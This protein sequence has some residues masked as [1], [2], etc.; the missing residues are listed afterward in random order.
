MNQITISP[1]KIF[2]RKIIFICI[3][4]SATLACNLPFSFTETGDVTPIEDI[5]QEPTPKDSA[6]NQD[7]SSSAAS[8]EPEP[9]E[10]S[11]EDVQ[12]DIQPGAKLAIPDCNIFDIG[13]FNSIVDG[14]F[15]FITQDQL[16]NCHFESNNDFRLLI[17]GGKPISVD[18]MKQLFDASFGTLPDSTWEVKDDHYLG[19]AYSTVS[20]TAQGISS[21]G[22]SMVI[23]IAS[24]PWSDTDAL[25]AI[26]ATLA[27]EAAQQLNAQFE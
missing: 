16:N 13:A 27:E 17:G 15:S 24:Q 12:I 9:T 19:L 18:E 2:T 14:E 21:S 4:I 20:I 26:F 8:P 7:D 22:H 1:R 11:M 5:P 3:L 10:A 23:V 25:K 6:G